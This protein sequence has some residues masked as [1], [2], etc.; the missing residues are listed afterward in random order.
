MPRGPP[1]DMRP[2]NPP[3]PALRPA[4]FDFLV[5][6][7]QHRQGLA[8]VLNHVRRV[9]NRCHG[10][11]GCSA[12]QVAVELARC[13]IVAFVFSAQGPSP[14]VDAATRLALHC[15]AL[16]GIY[17]DDVHIDS[18]N[19]GDFEGIC[20]R[21]ANR[22]LGT[23][24]ERVGRQPAVLASSVFHSVRTVIYKAPDDAA[25]CVLEVSRFLAQSLREHNIAVHPANISRAF[26]KVLA[27]CAFWNG[28]VVGR[29][30]AIAF[31][32]YFLPG[33]TEDPLL[34]GPA[35]LT[36]G[37]LATTKFIRLVA[38]CAV[39]W[40]AEDAD[41]AGPAAELQEHGESIAV[42][43]VLDSL[44]KSQND[45]HP[46]LIGVLETIVARELPDLPDPC[47]TQQEYN[48]V[49]Y[50]RESHPL[51]VI[52]SEK[53]AVNLLTCAGA[54]P[55]N[56]NPPAC[57]LTPAEIICYFPHTL[58]V[59]QIWRWVVGHGWTA[60]NIPKFV[61]KA[62]DLRGIW[63]LEHGS[64]RNWQRKANAMFRSNK[65]LMPLRHTRRLDISPYH[66]PVAADAGYFTA[67]AKYTASEGDLGAKILVRH[68]S[69]EGC[70][71]DAQGD[72]DGGGVE[73]QNNS[74]GDNADDHEEA[75]DDNENEE[76][77]TEDTGDDESDIKGQESAW[78]DEELEFAS[79]LD[80]FLD[81]F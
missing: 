2:L 62:R 40:D 59:P 41:V 38:W 23:L 79:N 29:T 75:K 80:C 9:A 63:S 10:A 67:M 36:V 30:F 69:H 53:F 8:R 64:F 7:P 28:I 6:L 72:G 78:E 34:P 26:E 27:A 73:P 77:A 46:I 16:V 43:H 47:L 4:S 55:I 32:Q 22:L 31:M 33:S 13:L 15:F 60:F 49:L 24:A 42:E 74:E 65:D 48:R 76:E 45:A 71:E 21:F 20:E 37:A 11:G 56:T 52:R 66:H 39:R 19:T 61:N 14:G 70:K 18:A 68:I 3:G 57:P 50:R 17:E 1:P 35:V 51:A 25:S 81:D 12:F 58:N 54:P 5:H 44:L